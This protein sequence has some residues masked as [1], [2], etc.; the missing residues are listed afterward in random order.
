EGDTIELVD[1]APG[2]APSLDHPLL[3]ALVERSGLGVRAKLGWTD[4]ARFAARGVPA[5]NLGAGDSALAH[6]RNERVEGD[7]LDVSYRALHDL[8]TTGP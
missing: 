2:A 8:I 5:V 7:R 4:V 1:V 6:N 3:L